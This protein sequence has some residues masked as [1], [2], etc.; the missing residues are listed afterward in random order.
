MVA[1]DDSIVANSAC[2]ETDAPHFSAAL[3]TGGIGQR[4]TA[5]RLFGTPFQSTG[6]SPAAATIS[7][8]R[9]LARGEAKDAKNAGI[10]TGPGS[11]GS[12]VVGPTAS[13]PSC[14]SPPG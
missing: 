12:R 6:R 1:P 14:A 11:R 8:V 2:H 10:S 13:I 3:E 4:H 5:R 7:P 9:E